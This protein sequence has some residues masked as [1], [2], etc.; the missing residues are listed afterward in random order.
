[1]VDQNQRRGENMLSRGLIVASAAVALVA[2]PIAGAESADCEAIVADTLAEIQAGLGAD[3][4]DDMAQAVRMASASACTKANSVRYA[5]SPAPM[6]SSPVMAD[7]ASAEAPQ[8]MSDAAD[9]AKGEE[10]SGFSIRPMS[11]S[12]TRKPYERSRQ[13]KE[14]NKEN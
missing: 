4:S 6:T 1:M 7:S 8:E 11:G 3:W 13:T 5:A 9:D 12:P 14:K 10:A 2:A